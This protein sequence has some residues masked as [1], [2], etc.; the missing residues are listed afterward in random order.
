[1]TAETVFLLD[2]DNTL[3]DNDR[4]TED[5]RQHLR[6][7]FGSAAGGYW[8]AYEALRNELGY[9]DY[10]GALQRFRAEFEDDT[11]SA[12]RLLTIFPRQ[13]H[14]AQDPTQ[15]DRHGAADLSIEHIGEL[16]DL[17]IAARLVNHKESSR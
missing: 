4:V 10:L 17:D 9:A 6:A 12:H 15:L 1:M 8:T 5:L 7:E 16:L 13:G 11:D 14:Y 3:L 2:V